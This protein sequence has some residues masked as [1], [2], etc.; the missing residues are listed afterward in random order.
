MSG[1]PKLLPPTVLHND[2]EGESVCVPKKQRFG[3]RLGE[4]STA[5]VQ[6]FTATLSVQGK[7][8]AADYYASVIIVEFVYDC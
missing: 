7:H 1:L 6:T 4:E 8:P 3:P 2:N 5:I